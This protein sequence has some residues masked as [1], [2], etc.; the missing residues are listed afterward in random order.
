MRRK[1]GVACWVLSGCLAHL[2]CV[3]IS[4]LELQEIEIF[5]LFLKLIG[6]SALHLGFPVPALK[7]EGW[8]QEHHTHCMDILCSMVV[9]L[10]G[11]H[12]CKVSRWVLDEL[13]A[14][15]SLIAVSAEQHYKY[16]NSG[17]YL[18]TAPSLM[19]HCDL[20]EE[21]RPRVAARQ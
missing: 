17:S 1:G 13:S 12:G 8:Q 5:C 6:P 7:G 14:K 10:A 21:V 9:T 19:Q 18:P 3:P 15:E 11:L 4:F 2:R 16:P 20:Q